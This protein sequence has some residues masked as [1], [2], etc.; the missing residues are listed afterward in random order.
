MA[1]STTIGRRIGKI[2]AWIVAIIV[3]LVIAL[4]VFILTFDWN[5]ARPYVNDKVTQAI[6]RQFTINGDLRVGLRHPVG[7]TGWKSWVPW[8]RFSAANITIANPD[9]AKR[10]Q[11][12]TLDEIDFQVK[13]LPLLAHDIVIPAINL[14]NPSVDLERMTDGRNNWTFELPKSKTP[15]QWKLQ[16]HD[17]VF[18]KGNIALS[19]EQKKVDAQMVVDTLGQPIPIGEALKQQEQA[20]RKASAEAVGKEGAKKLSAQADAQAASAAS[21]AAAAAASGASSTDIHASGTTAATG[22]SGGLVAGGSKGASAV[23]G[24]SGAAL[25]SASGAQGASAAGVAGGTSDASGASGASATTAANGR[26]RDIPPYAIGWTLK[27]TYNKTPVSGSG[28]VGGV[29]ALQDA[30]RPFPVQ[31]D[32]KAGDLHVGLVGTITDPAHLAAVDL[33]L[34]VQGSSMAKLYSLTGVTLPDTPP[35][36]TEGRF[37][38]QFKTTGNVFKYENFT[39]RVGGSDLNGSLIYTARQPRPLLQGELESRLLQ[40]SDLAPVIGADSNASKAKRGDGTMQPSNKA[41]PV[42]EFRTDRWKAIDADVKFTGRRIVKN[43]DLPITDLYTHIVM[44]NGVLSLEPLKFGV[45]GGTLASNIHLDGSGAPL[46]AR[47]ATSARHLKLK[48][49][50][51]NFKTM[52]DAL[53]EINGDAALTATGNSPAAL[54]ATSNGEVKAL[55]TEGTVSR[56]LMEAAGLNVA[57]VV[58]EKLFGNRDVKINCAAAD[59]V[60]TDG[61]LESR[62]FALDTDDAVI[63]IDGHVNMRDETMDL[64]VHPHTKGFRVFSLRSPLYAKGTFKN[65]HVGVNA[66][67]LALRGGA[68]VGLGLVNPFAALLP[69]LAPSNNKPLPCAQL[70]SQVRQAPKAPPP[71]TKQPPKPAISLEGAPVNK[72]SSAGAAAS[73]PASASAPAGRKAVPASPASAAEY[74]GS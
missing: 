32:V 67:A 9:W 33:R 62:V 44:T 19:D 59:F 45:A 13:V 60:A 53:G 52:Q 64:G 55:V 74:K 1:G 61:V 10:P 4:T 16:L 22:A 31:A 57:N 46:K 30:N 7:E 24:A 3:I 34:W 21:A 5:R 18:T 66:A 15:S 11:F 72:R 35:Y 58:Y 69:L 70:L 17:I 26:P 8:P 41:L 2:V 27:G 29:L 65:P 51:P 48:Q 49:L 56:L 40:F 25:A 68:A 54:A 43:A 63:D 47:F 37:V 6:G 39:G 28:K 38:G 23:T 73:A 50:F 42:E 36:A 12:A 14:V 71:G 20:S